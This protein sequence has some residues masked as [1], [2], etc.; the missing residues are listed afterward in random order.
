[1]IRIAFSPDGS[2]NP[3]KML[4]EVLKGNIFK[5]CNEQQEKGLQK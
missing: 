4:P 5:D 3:L 1:M 2:E